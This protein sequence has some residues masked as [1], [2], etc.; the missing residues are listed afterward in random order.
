MAV[1]E[2]K[3]L[4]LNGMQLRLSGSAVRICF[5]NGLEY[6]YLDIVTVKEDWDFFVDVLTAASQI[7]S[8]RI[9]EAEEDEQNQRHKK[10]GGRRG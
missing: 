10:F 2:A 3:V 6:A 7:P 8:H 1:E 9:K 5:P 4:L